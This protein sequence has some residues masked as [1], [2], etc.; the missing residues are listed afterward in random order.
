MNKF[1]KGG[2][3]NTQG[4]FLFTEERNQW[5]QQKMEEYPMIMISRMK[6]MKMTTLSKESIYP[7][8]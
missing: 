4:N 1:N 7:I 3:Q 2:D 8:Q 5:R 6:I